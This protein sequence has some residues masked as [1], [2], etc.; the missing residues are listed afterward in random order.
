M[1]AWNLSLLRPYSLASRP[2]TT[3]RPVEAR[4]PLASRRCPSR[5]PLAVAQLPSTQP[6]TAPRGAV[7]TMATAVSTAATP[8]AAGSAGL[9]SNVLPGLGFIGPG[10]GSSASS[11]GTSE[12]NWLEGLFTLDAPEPHT[13]GSAPAA[14]GVSA[15]TAAADLD[16]LL[17]QLTGLQ[18]FSRELDSAA[19]E[20]SLAAVSL[21]GGAGRSRAR[22]ACGCWGCRRRRRPAPGRRCK[23]PRPVSCPPAGR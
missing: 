23:L 21:A 3:A 16:A 11:P 4:W 6:S 20:F 15:G 9:S 22:G 14:A 5:Q 17:D 7:Q 13:A 18:Q 19:K 12:L 10:S 2:F 8:A 1:T